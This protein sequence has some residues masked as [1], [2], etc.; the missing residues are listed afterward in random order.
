M[1]ASQ[2]FLLLVYQHI[3]NFFPLTANLLIIYPGADVPA[4][5]VELPQASRGRTTLTRTRG[6]D[7]STSRLAVKD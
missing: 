3:Q 4:V 1:T 6:A 5:K 7:L 2:V